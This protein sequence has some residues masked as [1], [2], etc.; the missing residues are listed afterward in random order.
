MRGA[1]RAAGCGTSA[2]G[3]PAENTAESAADNTSGGTSSEGTS[4]ENAPAESTASESS[5][6]TEGTD[7]GKADVIVYFPNWNL[8][9]TATDLGKVASIP[10]DS[11]TEIHH[12]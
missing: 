4:A 7:M 9:S 1:L 6:Q 5:L 10:W 3:I 11:V 12:A 8:D 2:E